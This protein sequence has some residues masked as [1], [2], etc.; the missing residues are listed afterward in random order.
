MGQVS[1]ENRCAFRS[2]R[3]GWEKL[4]VP[5]EGWAPAMRLEREVGV[6]RHPRP[7]V[8]AI[9]GPGALGGTARCLPPAPS[10]FPLK[11]A[12]P[13]GCI[14]SMLGDCS[15]PELILPPSSVVSTVS[16][17]AQGGRTGGPQGPEHRAIVQRE[18]TKRHPAPSP[19]L[20]PSSIQEKFMDRHPTKL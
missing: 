17:P 18:E 7:I 12:G 20:R 5:R 19:H 13:R 8:M 16:V 14:Q 9:S 11:E 2:L 4:V 10:P 15:W 6:P 1:E 3:E